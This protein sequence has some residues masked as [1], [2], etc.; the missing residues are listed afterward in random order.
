[1]LASMRLSATFFVLLLLTFLPSTATAQ[2][3]R[4]PA[5][6]IRTIDGDTY[7]LRVDLGFDVSFTAT[8][9]LADLD[10]P[11]RFTEEGKRASAAADAILRSGPITVEPTG[12]RTFAR[13]VAHVYV[14]G[15]SLAAR[16]IEAGHRKVPR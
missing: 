10:T 15:V 4:Y 1:M 11:E 9:R 5:E 12:A 2:P 3:V 16:L 14:G 7:V 6:I 8:I 13:H